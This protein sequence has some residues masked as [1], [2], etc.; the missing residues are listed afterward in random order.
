MVIGINTA[1]ET[2]P[3]G[4]VG[5]G[6]AIPSNV[7][8]GVLATL[9]EGN[10]VTRPWIGISG[11]ALTDT[12][13]QDLDLS[14]SRGVYVVSV[15]SG[16]PAEAAGLKGG[17]L[18][19]SGTPAAGGDVITAVDGNNVATVQDISNYINTRTPGDTV[20]LSILR[21]GEQTQLQLT[22]GTWPS[23]LSSGTPGLNPQPQ[24][25]PLPEFPFGP[26]WRHFRQ[27]VPSE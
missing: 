7:A 23:N 18:S 3:S 24:P 22:L 13:A 21:D 6:F 20:T 11:T 8:S 26:G 9:K 2:S 14:I 17:N 25:T 15:I 4:A 27:S 5:I 19:I 16:S 1:I 10:S 12:L